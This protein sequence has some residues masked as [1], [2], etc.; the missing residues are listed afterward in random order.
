MVIKSPYITHSVQKET[1]LS[2]RQKNNPS[3]CI[4]R[5]HSLSLINHYCHFTRSHLNGFL[6]QIAQNVNIDNNGQV[7]SHVFH[8]VSGKKEKVDKLLNRKDEATWY[9][10]LSNEL[11]RL[12]QGV[13]KSRAPSEK[14]Y[15]T[16]F[17][18]PHHK[19]HHDS[20]VIYAKFISN[21][22]PLTSETN[23]VRFIVRADNLE[24]NSNSSSPFV[25]LLSIKIF[26]NSV[27]YGTHKG[28]I[29]STVYMK[30]FYLNNPMKTFQY[31]PSPILH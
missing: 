1:R 2:S 9:R 27:I 15:G 14:V 8:H 30:D 4:H 19:V 28:T 31:N 26:Y 29:Y 22:I 21:I 24:Y 5:L 13:G 11:N 18:I 6:A 10:S 23:R 20:N 12:V 3:L 17:F 16:I 7:D 25:S